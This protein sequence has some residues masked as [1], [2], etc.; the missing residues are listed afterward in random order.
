MTDLRLAAAACQLAR[1]VYYGALEAHGVTGVLW[2]SLDPRTKA[3]FVTQA[4]DMLKA[5]A[6]TEHVQ[7]LPLSRTH[8]RVIGA[9]TPTE[10]YGASK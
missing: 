10:P 9:I 5:H 4:A 7:P 1:A 6:P 2:E 8:A 3:I